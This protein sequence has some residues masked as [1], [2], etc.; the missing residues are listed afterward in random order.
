MSEKPQHKIYIDTTERYEKK[1][2]LVEVAGDKEK[3]IDSKTGDLDT[4]SAIKAI[5]EKNN[6]KPEDIEEFEPDT[7]P[8][9]FTGIK[10]GITIANILNWASGK[11]KPKRYKPNYGKEPNIQK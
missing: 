8:G 4:V 2:E 9:S 1:V 5:L 11:K 7:G 6:L 10:I 3:V